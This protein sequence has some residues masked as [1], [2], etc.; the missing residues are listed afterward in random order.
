[1][2]AIALMR[3]SALTGTARY[4][5]GAEAVLTAMGPA[6]G[7]APVAFTGSVAA[8]ELARRGLTEVVVTGTRPDLVEVVRHRYLPGA[9]LAWGEPYGSPLWE[10]RTGPAEAGRAF[11]C[12]NYTCLAPTTDPSELAS[13]LVA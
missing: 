9:V 2:A 5:D 1:V 10:G 12:H 7:L 8:T 6:L 11:V 3:L 4:G 13:Q